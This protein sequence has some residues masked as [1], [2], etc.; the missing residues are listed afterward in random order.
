MQFILLHRS[1]LEELV[2][3]SILNSDPARSPCWL[4]VAIIWNLM[5]DTQDDPSHPKCQYTPLSGHQGT[6][7]TKWLVLKKFWWLSMQDLT[8]R[9]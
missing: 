8:V 2:H 4:F 7:Q 3:K 9:D 6:Q 5:K 1:M